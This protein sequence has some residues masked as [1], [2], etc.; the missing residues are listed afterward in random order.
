MKKVTFD[1]SKALG[2][3]SEAEIGY[4]ETQ[5]NGAVELLHSKKVFLS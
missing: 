1:Y 5:V 4:M 2:F 3:F